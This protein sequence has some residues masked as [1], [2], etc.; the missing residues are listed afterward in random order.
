MLGGLGRIQLP[1]YK[2]EKQLL[3]CKNF[4]KVLSF[5]ACCTLNPATGLALVVGVAEQINQLAH[6]DG[7]SCG[8]LSFK[9]GA[10][11]ARTL[12]Q[13][14]SAGAWQSDIAQKWTSDRTI[15]TVDL[16]EKNQ[17]TFGANE[18][19]S[20]LRTWQIQSRANRILKIEKRSNFQI[21][22]EYQNALDAGFPVELCLVGVLSG[23]K[24]NQ[25]DRLVSF[26][27]V[28]TLNAALEK[29]ASDDIQ[30]WLKDTVPRFLAKGLLVHAK[31][32]SIYKNKS[33]YTTALRFGKRTFANNVSTRKAIAQAINREEI[34][35]FSL[36]S[37]V[38]PTDDL[39]FNE[40]P[41]YIANSKIKFDASAAKK[42]FG[43]KAEKMI[44]ATEASDKWIAAS[45]GIAVQLKRVGI[46][47]SVK[48]FNK[49]S[50]VTAFID[51]CEKCIGLVQIP[52]AAPNTLQLL[53]LNPTTISSKTILQNIE[54]LNSE[55]HLFPLW[56]DMN[57]WLTNSTNNKKT[58]VLEDSL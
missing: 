5:L 23:Q 2:P 6:E 51:T 31:G 33:P 44:L 22:I 17:P 29:L 30:F 26:V 4:L 8:S 58:K 43:T 49:T 53:G 15:V 27:N 24:M 10:R 19:V 25:S 56:N 38:L 16:N 48:V 28:P 42:L 47:I 32:I 34:I 55:F 7:L 21:S 40:H 9:I 12:F 57:V 52:H 11:G 45:K 1:N 3:M 13:A 36:N 50:E 35:K 54:L 46:E 18:V 39:F 14:T 41:L 20:S 37:L